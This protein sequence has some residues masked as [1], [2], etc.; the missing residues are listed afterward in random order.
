ML[1]NYILYGGIFSAYLIPK[2][3]VPFSPSP[4]KDRGIFRTGYAA[5]GTFLFDYASKYIFS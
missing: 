2:I 3:G 1:N 4:R 5:G